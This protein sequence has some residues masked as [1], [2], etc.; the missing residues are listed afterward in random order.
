MKTF[1]NVWK[2]NMMSFDIDDVLRGKIS[3]LTRNTKSGV[4]N[5]RFLSTFQ[6]ILILVRVA[7]V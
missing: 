6:N 5:N 4:N 3:D 1:S 7:A 2:K